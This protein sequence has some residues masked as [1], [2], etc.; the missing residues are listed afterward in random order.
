MPDYALL[1]GIDSPAD[2]RRLALVQ[3]PTLCEA[4]REELLASVA[5]TGGHLA[6]G[7]G[8]VELTVAIHAAFDTP[9]DRLIWDVGHQAYPHKM[10]TGRRARLSTLRQWGGLSG[11]PQRD[12]SPCDDFGV[13]HAGTSIS[14]VIGMA[15]ADQAQG[16]DNH[17][18]AV[19]GD[20]ALTAGMA[21]EALQHA[22]SLNSNVLVIVN[23][24]G[25]S[26][27]PN[28]G[29]LS[30]HLD[31]LTA[32]DTD[33]VPNF[34]SHLGFH[35]HGPVDGH[36]VLGLVTTL[37]ALQ[38]QSGPKLLHV[39]TQKGRGYLPA[40]TAPVRYHGIAPFSLSSPKTTVTHTAARAV[41]FTEVFSHWLTQTAAADKRLFAITPAMR[42]G[43]GL[44]AFSEQFPERYIDV[45][46]AEQHA[47]TLAAGMACRG[48]KPVVAIYSTFLQRA[49]DQLIHDVA[50][51]RLD[52]L[53]AVDRA[54]VVGEDGATH[55]GAF[56]L[57]FGRCVPHLV[58]MTPSDEVE[59]LRLLSAGYHYDGPALVRY[60]KGD[61]R[62]GY[63]PEISECRDDE[64]AI[65]KAKVVR[66]GKHVAILAFGTLLSALQQS[67]KQH[68]ATLVD[69]RFV[70]PLDTALID[71]FLETH[72]RVL[73]VEEGVLAGGVGESIAQY[74]AAQSPRTVV[75]CLGL[76]D[77]FVP[78]GSRQTVLAHYGLDEAG[79]RTAIVAFL[80][81]FPVEANEK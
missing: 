61:G 27:S 48:V 36:D 8:V 23:D 49:Y 47:V 10:L 19:I 71:D 24:N 39:K 74:I 73:V 52:V 78:H 32:A 60:P 37:K 18:I 66:R 15:L 53:F 56:D 51:Q 59:L 33:N 20:G 4:L 58:I 80:R 70:K 44:L 13:G 30:A 34:F 3:L 72:S 2:V 46:I 62:L 11:F 77:N 40:E 50:L 35:Y 79:L 26:I 42:E 29:A 57:A 68:D 64:L 75:R 43:S 7:L 9:R 45:G 25:F 28:V 22:G 67:A 12:E 65:G 81:E 63:V 16:R 55:A 69:M 1:A 38:K 31:A 5:Q 14:A 21:L 17:H 54:G 41:T 76:P 6:S